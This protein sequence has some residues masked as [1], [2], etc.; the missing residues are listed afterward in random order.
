MSVITPSKGCVYRP[1]KGIGGGWY[2]LE[3]LASGGGSPILI[4]GAQSTDLDLVFPVTALGNIKI[5]YTFGQNF[6]NM[7]VMGAVLC[8]PAGSNGGSFGKVMSFF[9]AKRVAKS[10]TPVNLSIPGGRG[11]KVYVTGLGLAAP[12]AELHVQPFM[13]YGLIAS[14]A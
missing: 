10:H 7:Q 14:P 6:G 1:S 12:D 11:Y 3:G 2:N 4:L 5:L 9:E 13:I 8:G